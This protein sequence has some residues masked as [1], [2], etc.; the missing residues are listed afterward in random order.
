[1]I[2]LQ[3]D[4]FEID[5]SY[6]SIYE[7]F[8]EWNDYLQSEE[9]A[10]LNEILPDLGISNLDIRRFIWDAEH[11]GNGM[12]Y[13]SFKKEISTWKVREYDEFPSTKFPSSN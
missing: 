6:T 9:P 10:D 4:N 7:S 12:S 2:D 13:D 1:M 3:T 5:L 8:E 11:S